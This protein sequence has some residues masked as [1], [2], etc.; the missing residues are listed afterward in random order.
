MLLRGLACLA[1]VAVALMVELA[2]GL[3]ANS[4]VPA[5]AELAPIAWPQAAR[6][7]WWTVVAVAALAYRRSLA[8][9]GLAGNR[10]VTVLSVAPFVV[11][12]GGVAAGADWATWH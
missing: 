9:V 12:A 8:Q 10:A 7:A 5:W 2:G 3:W 1:F 4:Q 6:V 11:F